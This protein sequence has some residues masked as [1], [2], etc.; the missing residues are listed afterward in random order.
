MFSLGVEPTVA[1]PNIFVSA[2]VHNNRFA[3]T[4]NDASEVEVHDR[5]RL[6]EMRIVLSGRR[7]HFFPP[8]W[9]RT[10]RSLADGAG[11]QQRLDYR[12]RRI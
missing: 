7:V 10:R 12:R 5:A 11:R 2:R 6:H 3:L 1:T 8:K 4:V 9:T